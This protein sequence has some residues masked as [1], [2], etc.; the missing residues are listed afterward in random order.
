MFIGFF[1]AEEVW[2]WPMT[3]SVPAVP[4]DWEA[5]I[6]CA[7]TGPCANA[8]QNPPCLIH[9]CEGF[10]GLSSSLTLTDC[11]PLTMSGSVTGRGEECLEVGVD[12]CSF[13]ITFSD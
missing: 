11:F 3:N 7:A 9:D 6:Y 13:T 4:A 5:D 2:E 10:G 8:L 12:D 1:G